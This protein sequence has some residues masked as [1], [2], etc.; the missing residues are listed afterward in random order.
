MVQRN[1]VD[2]I[3]AAFVV[4]K[5]TPKAARAFHSILAQ[6]AF[7]TLGFTLIAALARIRTLLEPYVDRL[8]LQLNKIKSPLKLERPGK[9]SAAAI[10]GGVTDEDIGE[11]LEVTTS[12]ISTPEGKEVAHKSSK[13]TQKHHKLK[14]KKKSGH[15]AIDDIFG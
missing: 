3:S 6:G 5:L 2:P 10:H 7:I 15:S 12:S 1:K 9:V 11:A 14:K 4:H 8:D 13:H